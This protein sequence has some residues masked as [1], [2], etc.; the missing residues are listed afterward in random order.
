MKERISKDAHGETVPATETAGDVSGLV[1]KRVVARKACVS[2]RCVDNW[3]AQR[4]IPAIRI[5]RRCIRFSL[6]AVMRA[7]ERFEIKEATR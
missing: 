7:L 1:T 3:I 6:P 2:P 4:K 5:S